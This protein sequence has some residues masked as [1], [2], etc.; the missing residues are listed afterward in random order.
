MA[1]TQTIFS[2]TVIKMAIKPIQIQWRKG[3]TGSGGTYN[4]DPIPTIERPVTGQK[5][6]E[7]KVPLLTGSVTQLLGKDS[8]VIRLHGV[9][10]VGDA[11]KFDVLDAKRRGLISGVDFNVGQLHIISNLGTMDSKHVYYRGVVRG[12]IFSEQTNNQILDY[13][14]EVLV[15][16]GV[17][18]IV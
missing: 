7:F 6:V 1:I 5:L 4:F 14:I 3:A 11:N 16:D 13:T 8:D 12:I 10:A 15:S 18:N 2:N 9:L 17:E